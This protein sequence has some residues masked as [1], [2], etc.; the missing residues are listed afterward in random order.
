MNILAGKGGNCLLVVSWP[1]LLGEVLERLKLLQ[2][3]A[4]LLLRRR[5]AEVIRPTGED[6][7]LAERL[8]NGSRGGDQV[9][10]LEARLE[11]IRRRIEELEG[12]GSG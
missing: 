1:S 11:D 3:I 7:E 6:R 4:G 5:G 8:L 9:S 10:R 2:R 12:G